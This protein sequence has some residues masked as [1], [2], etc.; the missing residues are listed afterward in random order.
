MYIP[1]FLLPLFMLFSIILLFEKYGNHSPIPTS[2]PSSHL[3]P[4]I[5]PFDISLLKYSSITPITIL[6]CIFQLSSLGYLRIKDG[7]IMEIKQYHGDTVFECIFTHIFSDTSEITFHDLKKK[8]LV[9]CKTLLRLRKRKC[10]KNGRRKVL[11]A[12]HFLLF[13]LGSVYMLQL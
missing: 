5:T 6:S 1:L 12:K 13:F 4:N 11:H 2:S 3:S 8:C 7:R 10:M 9:S